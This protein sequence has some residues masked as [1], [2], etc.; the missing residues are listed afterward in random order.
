MV[1]MFQPFQ[2]KE[3]F[4][5][6]LCAKI[7]WLVKALTFFQINEELQI[8]S[9]LDVALIKITKSANWIVHAWSARKR[10]NFMWNY[11]AG[12]AAAFL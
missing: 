2:G 5:S 6:M 12:Q 11:L 3:A 7:C 4:L 10:L 1:M 9:L 8:S